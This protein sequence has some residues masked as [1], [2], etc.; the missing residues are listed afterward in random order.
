MSSWCDTTCPI[1]AIFF[2]RSKVTD[3][4]CYQSDS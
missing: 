1:D 3:Q 2:W 4:W